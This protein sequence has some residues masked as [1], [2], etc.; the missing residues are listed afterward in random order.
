ME[1]MRPDSEQFLK[2][3]Q[4][5]E[6]REQEKN[7]GKMNP[8]LGYAAGTGKTYAMLEAAHEAEKSGIDVVAGYIE[9]HNRPDTEALRE[10]LE[11][12]PPLMVDY[13]GIQ[14]REF[15]LDAALK[16]RPQL[17]LVDELAHTPS[18]PMPEDMICEMVEKGIVMDTTVGDPDKGMEPPPMMDLPEGMEPPEGMGPPPGPMMPMDP[19][20]MKRQ[21]AEKMKVMEENLGRFYR[22]GGKIVVGTDL[23]HSRD[24]RK[25]AVIPVPE[26]RHLHAAGLPMNAILRAATRSGAE[27]VG[28]G[29]TEGRLIPGYLAN[30]VAVPG[31]VDETFEALRHVALVM[32]RGTVIRDE[33]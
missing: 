24:Y 18:D 32:H 9:P 11:E 29:A 16:R 10:G 4:Y 14:L 17:L 13:K 8:F 20:E 7:R 26:L 33:R 1:E 12:I 6:K 22:A 21:Q 25:D 2:R 19:A 30:L 27:V 15:D 3:I 28:T 5:E 23:I 31:R